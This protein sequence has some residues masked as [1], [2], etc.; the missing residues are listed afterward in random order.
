MDSKVYT[1]KNDDLTVRYDL[2]RCIH[3]AECVHGLR[4]VFDP[5]RRPWIDTDQAPADTIASVIHRCP[6]GALHYDRHDGGAAEPVPEANTIRVVP[7]GPLYV[8]GA[9]RLQT[10]EG[11]VLLEDTRVALC[12]CGASNNKPLCDN[13]HQKAAFTD[14]GTLGSNDKMQATPRG[15]AGALTVTAAPHGPLLV[16]GPVS[17]E[18]AEGTL[19]DG[20][21]VALC[22][23]GHSQNKPYCDGSHKSAGFTT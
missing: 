8:H 11:Q 12:R 5:E 18:G 3:A 15:E 2:K 9:V 4:P 20:T 6:T 13:S 16:K 22:R 1:Y 10:A 19:Q 17:L 14:G 21:T 23:C 7:D